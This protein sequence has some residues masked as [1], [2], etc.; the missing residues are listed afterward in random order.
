MEA[1]RTSGT[2]TCV[3]ENIIYF[4]QQQSLLFQGWGPMQLGNVDTAPVVGHYSAAGIMLFFYT[5]PLRMCGHISIAVWHWPPSIPYCQHMG[6]WIHISFRWQVSLSYLEDRFFHLCCLSSVQLSHISA[7][8]PTSLVI[9]P[10]LGCVGV[11]G[12]FSV[13]DTEAGS[14]CLGKCPSSPPPLLLF[15][16]YSPNRLPPSPLHSSPLA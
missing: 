4:M 10:G 5:I 9:S 6:L 8:R 13:C 15:P 3:T 16:L 14:F 1:Q 11:V 12:G 2:W 7:G